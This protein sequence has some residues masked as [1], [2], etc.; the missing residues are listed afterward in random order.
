MYLFALKN[1]MIPAGDSGCVKTELSYP[2]LETFAENWCRAHRMDAV[3]SM[4]SYTQEMCE[5]SPKK[6]SAYVRTFGT[7]VFIR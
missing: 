2:H 3:F 4:P 1:G 6:L 5:M 7:L